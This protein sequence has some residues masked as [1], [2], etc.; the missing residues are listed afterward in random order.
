VLSQQPLHHRPGLGHVH[1]AGIFGLELGHPGNG[2]GPCIG[3][4]RNMVNLAEELT[5][6]L[7]RLEIFIEHLVAADMEV[8]CVPC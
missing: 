2:K 1:L 5:A 3:Q 6:A 7:A 8:P 4:G